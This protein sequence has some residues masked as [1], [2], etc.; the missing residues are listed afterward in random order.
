ML[1]TTNRHLRIKYVDAAGHQQKNDA[2]AW[3]SSIAIQISADFWH[4]ARDG[5]FTP[6]WAERFL[7]TTELIFEA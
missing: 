7:R 6:L 1:D 4:L 2:W 3:L 5:W